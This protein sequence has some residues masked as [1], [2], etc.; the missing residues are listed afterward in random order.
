MTCI[1]CAKITTI[2]DLVHWTCQRPST[3]FN[4]RKSSKKSPD[5]YLRLTK[6]PHFRRY[7]PKK[8]PVKIFDT[9]AERGVPNRK[10]TFPRKKKQKTL[11]CFLFQNVGYHTPKLSP[12]KVGKKVEKSSFIQ[13]RDIR[14]HE[15]QTL[16]VEGKIVRQ[17][18]L[19]FLSFLIS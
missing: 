1:L 19:R 14:F 12:R 4:I 9:D 8:A 7:T 3:L 13:K 16:F 2:F 15:L 5:V 10:T 18:D 6:S 17:L 11:Q